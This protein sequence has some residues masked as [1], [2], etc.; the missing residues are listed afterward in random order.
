M[1]NAYIEDSYKLV[2]PLM[3]NG[4]LNLDYDK[5]VNH[6][7]GAVE[8][9]GVLVNN[10]SGISSGTTTTIAV[11]TVDATTKFSIEDNVFDDTGTLVGVVS[12][13]TATQIT[14]EANNA[15]ALNNNE[16]LKKNVTPTSSLRDRSIWS[17]NADIGIAN[18]FVLE[19][20]ITPYDV[21]GAG[22]R[23][24]GRHGVLDS[25]RTPPYPTDAI[26]D[27]TVYESVDYLGASAYLTQKMMLFHNQHHLL[28]C[29]F[30]TSISSS[31]CRTQRA[32]HTTNLLSTR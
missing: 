8:S 19:A 31:T 13:V 9:S 24:S 1:V 7:A 10:G 12:A 32:V 11:D 29:C 18:G 6:A 4:Y 27:R 15:V 21:N 30:T 25:Q 28:R 23:A 26:T 5:A 17:D 14:L 20:I 16:N 22:S 3:C 2:F